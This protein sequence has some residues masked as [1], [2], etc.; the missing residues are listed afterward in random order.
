MFH[1]YNFFFFSTSSRTR[2]HFLQWNLGPREQEQRLPR[3]VKARGGGGLSKEERGGT[4]G[5]GAFN[6][7]QPQQ[8]AVVTLKVSILKRLLSHQEPAAV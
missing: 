7:T 8:S 5:K 2:S 3:E 1:H 4:G 6:R